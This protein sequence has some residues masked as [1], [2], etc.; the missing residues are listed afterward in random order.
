[1]INLITGFETYLNKF[2]IH[3]NLSF[4]KIY[5]NSSFSAHRKFTTTKSESQASFSYIRITNNNYF[6]YSFLLLQTYRII[7]NRILGSLIF[8]YFSK[9]TAKFRAKR[10]KEQ[11]QII[12]NYLNKTINCPSL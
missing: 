8:H 12:H 11:L 7:L 6:E 5:S 2:T 1:M 3:N 4:P 9:S 10:I